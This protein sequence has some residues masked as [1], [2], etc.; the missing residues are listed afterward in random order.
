[1]EE[2]KKMSKSLGNVVDP[3]EVCS[4]YG[5]DVLR[6]WLASSD[7]F[8]DIRIS[9]NIIMQQVEVY[10]K[11]RNTF[12]YLLGN[13]D[14]FSEK[15]SVSFEQLLPIDKWAMGRL[16]EIIKSVTESY[17]SYEFSKVYNILVKYCSV[18]LSAVYLDIIKD[19]LYVESKN[20]LAR[21]SAQTV[22]YHILRSLLIMLSP[23]LAFTCEEAYEHFKCQQQKFLSVQVEK[24]PEYHE[25]WIDQ[26]VTSDFEELMK[27][28]DHVL[29][30]LEEVRQ[31]GGIGHS[32]DARVAI[33][34]NSKKIRTLLERY[35]QYLEELFIVSQVEVHD[36]DSE[37]EVEVQKALGEKCDRCWKY[38]PM[39]GHDQEFP[40]TCPRCASVL[41]SQKG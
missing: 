34:S 12:R 26:E 17:E 6:L 25:E 29:K 27:I 19:R 32:L 1:D 21:R 31:S 2:G 8:N 10:K 5:A 39:T 20:S 15:D 23:I 7:Y 11:I 18:E 33:R 38:H 16:Q 41:R 3:L 14:D 9:Q 30:A 37:L 35:A 28:R 36:S 24:W 22:L 4:K 13:L 40:A